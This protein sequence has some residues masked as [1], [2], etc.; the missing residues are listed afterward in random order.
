MAG[1]AGAARSL[2]RGARSSHGPA[3]GGGAAGEAR[4][5]AEAAQPQ[6]GG[7]G[8]E[9]ARGRAGRSPKE[10][11]HPTA[12]ALRTWLRRSGWHRIVCNTPPVRPAT[13]LPPARGAGAGASQTDRRATFADVLP[14]ARPPAAASVGGSA[15]GLRRQAGGRWQ[16]PSPLASQQG[17]QRGRRGA[18][19]SGRSGGRQKPRRGARVCPRGARG[20]WRA[21]GAHTRPPRAPHTQSE[22]RPRRSGGAMAAAR[23]RAQRPAAHP[24]PPRESSFFEVRPQGNPPR[25]RP[26]SALRRLVE[27]DTGH[28]TPRS[29]RKADRKAGEGAAPR[30]LRAGQPPAQQR[31]RSAAAGP[32]CR[33]APAVPPS[34]SALSTLAC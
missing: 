30:V 3:Q 4:G 31:R 27:G 25:R 2:T 8:G 1:R 32:R 11:A 12:L 20:A 10:H 24:S 17:T 33:I 15:A 16:G 13:H 9:G 29:R 21:P 28:V 14:H 19:R 22:P 23:A 5:A 7:G 18:R 6:R 26:P 34:S